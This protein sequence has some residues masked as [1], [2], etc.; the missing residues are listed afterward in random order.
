MPRPSGYR[1]IVAQVGLDSD[2]P[3]TSRESQYLGVEAQGDLRRSCIVIRSDRAGDR[4]ITDTASPNLIW[5]E[6]SS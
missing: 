3:V 5:P 6:T 4:V 2:T 1:F